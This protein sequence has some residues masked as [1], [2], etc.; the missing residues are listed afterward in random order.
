MPITVNLRHV[1]AHNK[2]LQGELPASELD[3][4]TRDEL[5]QARRSLEYDLEVQKLEDGLLVQGKLR[6]VLDCECARCLKRIE[7]PIELDPWTAHLPL[8]GEE[9]VA[10]ANDLV[11]LTPTIREDILLEFPQHPLCDPECVG[12]PNSLTNK[13][14][15]TGS[16]RTEGGSSAWSELNKLKF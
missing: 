5:I 6:L 7:Y 13:K 10:V 2:R 14:K 3:L 9:K 4:D 1:E 11:D 8:E 16:G 12:L 15:K